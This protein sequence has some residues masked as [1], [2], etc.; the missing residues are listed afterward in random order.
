MQIMLSICLSCKW[1]RPQPSSPD[2]GLF[3][4]P[5][6]K[7]FLE[8]IPDLITEGLFDHRNQYSDETVLFELDDKE[9]SQSLFASWEDLHKRLIQTITIVDK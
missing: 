3:D 4:A 9:D 8:G 2:I 5:V 1:K 6:C 7:A